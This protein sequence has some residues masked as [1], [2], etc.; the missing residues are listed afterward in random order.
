[1]SVGT[2]LRR[3]RVMLVRATKDRRR[4]ISIGASERRVSGFADFGDIRDLRAQGLGPVNTG[5]EFTDEEIAR[6]LRE[7]A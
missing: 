5:P 4:V 3:L 2:V 7:V 1:M 6:L